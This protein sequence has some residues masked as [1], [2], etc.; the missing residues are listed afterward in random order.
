MDEHAI[1]GG[2]DRQAIQCDL[3]GERVRTHPERALTGTSGEHVRSAGNDA[4]WLG[5]AKTLSSIDANGGH[6]EFTKN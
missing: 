2:S 3:V 4:T 1:P 5:H 6:Y